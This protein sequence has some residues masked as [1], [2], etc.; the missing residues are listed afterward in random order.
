MADYENELSGGNYWDW[1][2]TQEI[3][4]PEDKEDI[5]TLIKDCF[6]F[7]KPYMDELFW[8]EANIIY[9]NYVHN[10]SQHTIA[11]YLDVTQLAVSKRLHSGVKKL[12][13]ALKRPTKNSMEVLDFLGKV[14][15]EKKAYIAMVYYFS[16]SYSHTAILCE[17]SVTRV[18]EIILHL[19]E[20]LREVKEADDS[21]LVKVVKTHSEVINIPDIVMKNNDTK[22]YEF[23]KDLEIHKRDFRESVG[24]YLEYYELLISSNNFG[25]YLFKRDEKVRAGKEFQIHKL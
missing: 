14:L 1:V 15:P 21:R 10:I 12:K 11:K 25:D 6:E 9:L 22:R 4:A 24:K 17:M 18:R 3:L 19:I 5:R 2:S 20:V 8:V 23:L 16:K 7:I 13:L